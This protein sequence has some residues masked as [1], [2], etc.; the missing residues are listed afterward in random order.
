MKGIYK[1][2][3]GWHQPN[4]RWTVIERGPD[5]IDKHGNKY[6]Q[7]WCQCDCGGEQSRK[8][9]RTQMITSEASKSCGCLNREV[10]K[11]V[12]KKNNITFEGF[13]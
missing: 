8:L 2:L 9:L 11:D 5:G 10:H 3:T 12:M 1:D 13:E 7:W 4:G 6:V